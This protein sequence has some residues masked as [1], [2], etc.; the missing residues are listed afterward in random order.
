M[1]TQTYKQCK[2][3]ANDSKLMLEKRMTLNREYAIKSE[4][5]MLETD[6]SNTLNQT[7]QTSKQHTYS[8][9]AIEW[10]W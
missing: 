7:H 2:Y 5:N 9:R 3:R 8:F 1:K 6:T 4:I 10:Y